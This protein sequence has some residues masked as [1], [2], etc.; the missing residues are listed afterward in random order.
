MGMKILPLVLCL[1]IGAGS[2]I[3]AMAD[4]SSK[5][6]PNSSITDQKRAKAR[7]YFLQGSIEASNQQMDRAYEYFK[8]AYETDP[9]FQDAAFTYGSQRLFLRNDTLQSE[10]EI[11]NSLGL[12]QGYVDS[13]PRDLY[14]VQLYGYVTSALDTVEEAIRVYETTYQLMPSETQ[15]LQM[16]ADSYMR[17]RNSEKALDALDKYEK[18]E[19]KSKDTSLKKISFKLASQDTLGAIDEARLLV[20]SNPRD[21]YSYILKGNLYEVV[22]DMDSVVKAYKDAERLA[23]EN[24]AV[25]MSLAQYY[26]SVGDSIELD[27]MVYEALI[28]EDFELEDKLGILGEYLQ[29]LLDEEGDR[30]RG[31]NLFLILQTQYPHEAPVLEMAAR[32]SAAKGEYNEAA[33]SIE[34]ALDM[35]PTNETYWMMLMSFSLADSQYERT[36]REY[37]KAKSHIE[38][39]L[40]MKNLYSAA[41]SMIEDKNE[42]ENIING[43]ILE[44]DSRLSTP[45]GRQ[46]VR[47]ILDYD[48]LNFVS[49]LYCILGDIHYKEGESDKAFDEYEISLSFMPDNPLTLN[50]YA[51]FLSEKGLELE[52]AKK[53]SRRVLDIVDNNPTYLDTYAWILFKLGELEEAKEYMQLALEIA[54][55]QGDENEEYQIH[56]EAIKAALEEGK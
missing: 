18:I 50:N 9:A 31:D 21:P 37:N 29:R 7:Y 5:I 52:K 45:E 10:K 53:M 54:E 40:Q 6:L 24:G 56:W 44:T 28:S 16:L 46:E 55:Q 4:A 34:Y 35:D 47:K 25:K 2:R 32:Y 22:G 19:G 39:S 33:E 1:I 41:A 15:L 20:E 49:S 26:R 8:K 14:A 48:H 38:P 12:M 36:V 42:A 13:N 17:L 27:N 11:F 30:V 51:Y 43:L 3:I 23:P